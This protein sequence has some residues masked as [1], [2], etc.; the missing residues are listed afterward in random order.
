MKRPSPA[1]AYAAM[2]PQLAEIAQS[3]GYAL[4]VHGSLQRDLDLIAVPWI[5]GP[6]PPEV[7]IEALREAVN[8]IVH[9]NGT[10]ANRWNG[11][12]WVAAVIENPSRKPH[13]RL[14]W[15]IHL[16]CGL[17]IDISVMPTQRAE[18]SQ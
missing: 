15:N 7:L 9:A 1:P 2:L 4:A 11:K 5:D 6:Q 13:G 10:P 14:A 8:G 17:V 18:M 12:E 3:R 16:E